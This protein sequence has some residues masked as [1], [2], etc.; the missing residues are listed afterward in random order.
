MT[1]G[2]LQKTQT[3]QTKS[4]SIGDVRVKTL[5]IVI[6]SNERRFWNFE[7][8]SSLFEL[9][10]SRVTAMLKPC[11]WAIQEIIWLSFMKSPCWLRSQEILALSLSW[12]KF[13][14]IASEMSVKC[15]LRIINFKSLRD[16]SLSLN[17]L[18]N[19]RIEIASSGELSWQNLV[20]ASSLSSIDSNS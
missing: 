20:L 1:C 16:G 18:I 9:V 19:A 4:P 14:F 5:L 7:Q 3:W 13:L 11:S 6:P 8:I 15:L 17:C 10:T 2:D 12:M